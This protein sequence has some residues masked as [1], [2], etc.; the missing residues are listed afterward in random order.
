MKNFLNTCSHDSNPIP[1]QNRYKGMEVE[2][3]DG[4]RKW[5]GKYWVYYTKYCCD[6]CSKEVTTSKRTNIKSI[7]LRKHTFCSVDCK[8]QFYLKDTDPKQFNILE[9]INNNFFYLIGLIASDGYIK[10]PGHPKTSTGYSCIIELHENDQI[11]LENIN[12][13]FGGSL[14]PNKNKQSVIWNINNRKYIQFLRN[15]VGLTNNKSLTMDIEN[16][17]IKLNQDQK[18]SFIRGLFDG[19]GSIWFTKSSNTWGANIVSHSEK[20]LDMLYDYFTTQSFNVKRSKNDIHFNGT[21]TIEPLTSFMT[22]KELH[23]PRKYSKFLE[24]KEFYNSI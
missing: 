12:N 20:M 8:W 23:M 2:T 15:E 7:N 18:Y 1:H 10:L 19:D 22:D 14:T 16:W 4:V 5:T 9:K 21:H 13:E 11:L 24:M 6:F 3:S 17:F